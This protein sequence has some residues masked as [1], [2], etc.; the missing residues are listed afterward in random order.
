MAAI[1]NKYTTTKITIQQYPTDARLADDNVIA[2]FQTAYPETELD[3]IQG[4]NK[5]VEEYFTCVH[6]GRDVV[7]SHIT[8]EPLLYN[9]EL[10]SAGE[11]EDDGSTDEDGEED[12][13][14]EDADDSGSDVEEEED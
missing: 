13:G 6:H 3:D 10:E 2:L 1:A 11:E 14:D 7:V 12:S 5:I 9:Q 4:N 8:G